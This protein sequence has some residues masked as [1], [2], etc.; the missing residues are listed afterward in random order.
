MIKNIILNI[1]KRLINNEEFKMPVPKG[2][3]YRYRKI[4]KKKRQRLAFVN[5]KVVEITTYHRRN[6]WVKKHT[7]RMP[8]K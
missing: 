1:E 6:G 7:R 3:R 8:R 5:N 2:I 4:S